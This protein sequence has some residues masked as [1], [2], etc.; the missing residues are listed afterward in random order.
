MPRHRAPRAVEAGVAQLRGPAGPP[1]TFAPAVLRTTVDAAQTEQHTPIGLTV[2]Q[3]TAETEERHSLS[4]RERHILTQ[5]K[6]AMLQISQQNE[7]LLSQNLLLKERLSKLEDERSTNQTTWQSAEGTHDIVDQT[8]CLSGENYRVDG[9]QGVG[10]SHGDYTTDALGSFRYEQGYQQGYLA[11]KQ[12]LRDVSEG[13]SRDPEGRVAVNGSEDCYSGYS[14][15][16]RFG[17][18]SAAAAVRSETPPP[19]MRRAW[20]LGC[21]TTPQGTPIPQGPPPSEEGIAAMNRGG[22]IGV[23]QGFQGFRGFDGHDMV[24]TFPKLSGGRDFGVG[25][26]PQ[27]RPPAP[28]AWNVTSPS[29]SGNRNQGN[30][31]ADFYTG[32][33]LG[34]GPPNG[35]LKEPEFPPLSEGTGDA[36]DPYAPGDKVYW[37][38]PALADTFEEPDPATRANDWLQMVGPIMSDITPMS[39]VWWNRVLAEAHWWYQ[40]W[41]QS[42]AI[43]RGLVRPTPTVQLQGLRYRRLESRAYAMLLAATPVSIRDELVANQETHC[44]ALLFHVL[45]TFQPGG[46]QERITLLEM[47]NNPG[48]T[49]VP[50]E[51]V[52]K[53]RSWGRALSRATSMQVSVP[54][55]SLMLRGLDL[56]ADPLLRKHP[57][58]SFRCSQARNMLQLDHRPSLQSVKEFVKVLQA[59]F[60]MLSLSGPA[61][62]NKK[63]KLA[64]MQQQQNQNQGGNAGKDTAGKG[65]DNKGNKKG[66]EQPTGEKADTTKQEEKGAGKGEGK[67]CGFYLTPKGCS[68]GRMCPFLHQYGKAKGESR[69]YN[70]GSLEH[71]Q[72]NCTRPNGKGGAQGQAQGQPKGK[73]KKGSSNTPANGPGSDGVSVTQGS[74]STAVGHSASGGVHNKGTGENGAAAP[75]GVLDNST[76]NKNQAAGT[77]NINVANAQAQVLEEAQKLLKSLRIAAMRVKQSGEGELEGMDRGSLREKS[78]ERVAGTPSSQGER[79][80]EEHRPRVST[81]DAARE[82]EVF[83]PSVALR[84]SKLPTGLLDGGATHA[85]R[86]AEP[87]E[88]ETSTPTRVTLAVG[89]QDLRISPVGTVL[90]P[91]PIAPIVPLGLLVDLLGRRVVWNAGTCQVTHPTRGELRVWLEDNCPVVSERDW[92]N[93]ISEIERHRASRLRQALHIRALGLGISPN[94]E[95]ED[96]SP[97]GSDHQLANWLKEQFPKAPDWL[98]LRSMPVK[99]AHQPQ[100]PFY[101]PGLNRRARKALKRA[102]HIVLHV[103]SG[104]TKAVEFTLG[105]EVADLDVLFGTNMLDERV[106]AAAAALCGT[107][108]VD[109]VVGGPPCCTN[110][111]LRNGGT[112]GW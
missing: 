91:D 70:C 105:S 52:Q 1:V 66:G 49:N 102:K 15:A 46:L 109:A 108:K 101:L 23:L 65:A 30:L 20:N 9:G 16:P 98:L 62:S 7:E 39:G 41:T 88:W 74:A 95:P 73:G 50:S 86:T 10:N 45:R 104:R 103:F 87:G 32:S 90:S 42:S 48:T 33:G 8:G 99:G 18:P 31:A 6:N 58:V 29:I 56:L 93:L 81:V 97:W 69:C 63:P 80:S 38:L 37:S 85:L 47:L 107:G 110:S 51:A 34:I 13:V 111:I 22:G 53:L 94:V 96:D 11:A 17:G 59:E 72:D 64:A 76:S 83:V 100:D 24:P 14:P 5:M 43:E 36:R 89:A 67:P 4:S 61:D 55:A 112:G 60:D 27:P 71:R 92:L 68:K 44:V 75:G 3:G 26:D 35:N 79:D 25:Q 84:R 28:P 2:E 12:V 19:N 21:N 82:S 77:P 106:Y 78:P 57:H 40:V 54:D